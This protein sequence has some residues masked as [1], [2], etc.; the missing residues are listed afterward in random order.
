M[1]KYGIFAQK[2]KTKRSII[3]NRDEFIDGDGFERITSELGITY[4]DAQN[5][6]SVI[7]NEFIINKIKEIS[8]EKYELK[9]PIK[10]DYHTHLPLLK[11]LFEE[12]KL[13]NRGSKILELGCGLGSS[14]FL[15]HVQSELDLEIFSFETDK[16]WY[17]KIQNY[18]SGEKYTF[19][20]INDWNELK[21]EMFE[22]VMFD[23]IFIDQSPWEARIVSALQFRNMCKF[24]A[25]HDY[26]YYI[27]EKPDLH[28]N[29]QDNFKYRELYYNIHP[30][31]LLLSNFVNVRFENIKWR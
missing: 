1:G 15:K 14:P 3:T 8:M 18:Y 27:R 29:I 7:D 11:Y 25:I 24:M 20:H 31:T 2:R 5:L 4:C 21:P 10:N 30:P 16:G 9:Y 26:D 28:C 23:F 13:I 12:A 19:M 6:S 22:G 17:D